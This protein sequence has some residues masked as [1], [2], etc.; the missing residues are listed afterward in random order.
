MLP[1]SHDPSLRGAALPSAPPPPLLSAATSGPAAAAT[2]T[3]LRLCRTIIADA[4]A[5][6]P[7]PCHRWQPKAEGPGPMPAA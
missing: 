6:M 4:V 7:L 5:V 1:A 2:R 3:A